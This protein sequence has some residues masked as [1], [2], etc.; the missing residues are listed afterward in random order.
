MTTSH[1]GMQEVETGTLSRTK[2][3]SP[4]P[5]GLGARWRGAGTRTARTIS[6]EDDGKAER[7]GPQAAE[8]RSHEDFSPR[9]G[10]QTPGP[11]RL[12]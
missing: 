5:A 11:L 3:W 7:S 8:F 2:L 10:V 9:L 6:D 12:G 1:S 4:T